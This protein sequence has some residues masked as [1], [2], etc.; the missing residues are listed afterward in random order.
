MH[1]VVERLFFGG[2][3]WF[4]IVVF[5]DKMYSKGVSRKFQKSCC[6]LRRSLDTVGKKV[7]WMNK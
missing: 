7:A 2:F 3:R 5:F 4:E 1:L 6:S